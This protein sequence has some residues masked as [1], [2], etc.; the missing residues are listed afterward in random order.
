MKKIIVILFCLVCLVGCATG[1]NH[2]SKNVEK[3]QGG[4]PIGNM[5]VI[6]DSSYD[7]SI[8][9]EFPGYK[10]LSVAILNASYNIIPMDPSHDTWSVRID[11][12]VYKT[13]HDLRQSNPE[14][15]NS[16]S[17]SKRNLLSYPLALPIGASFVIDLFV[18]EDVPLEKYTD[19]IVYLSG[20]N[21][22]V[23]ILPRQ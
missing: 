12:K 2:S 10:V 15:W 21:K 5:G 19:L 4:T 18:T 13:V 3:V 20:L 11:N 1:G 8:N 17:E 6:I 9:R 23:E 16:F 22:K 7:E 14:L